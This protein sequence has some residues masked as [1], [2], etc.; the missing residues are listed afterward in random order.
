MPGDVVRRMIKGKDTQRGYCRHMEVTASIQIVG[1][2][3]IINGVNSK[4]LEPIEV[5]KNTIWS[6]VKYRVISH[7]IH[8]C[9]SFFQRLWSNL[10]VC[11]DSWVGGIKDVHCKL[12][13]SLSD[14]SKCTV[15]DPETSG[16]DVFDEKKDPVSYS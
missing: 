2:R 1:T 13:L 5:N 8:S 9:F 15:S 4:N 7:E 6:S 11:L 3:H 14:G 12:H 10:A 16:F